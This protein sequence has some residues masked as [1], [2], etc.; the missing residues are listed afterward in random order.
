[1]SAKVSTVPVSRVF[2]G[3]KDASCM[4]DKPRKH[5]LAVLG[6]CLISI[7]TSNPAFGGEAVY[8]TS[9]EKHLSP[10]Y[11]DYAKGLVWDTAKAHS[12]A[13]SLL[14]SRNAD[15]VFEGKDPNVPMP[16][17]TAFWW[18]NA[19][20]SIEPST[21]YSISSWALSELQKGEAG[22]TISYYSKGGR[23]LGKPTQFRLVNGP[24][25][26]WVELGGTITTPPDA[27]GIKVGMITWDTE[28]RVWFDDLAIRTGPWEVTVP[29]GTM[30]IDGVVTPEKWQGAAV[31]KDFEKVGTSGF[32]RP[33]GE[34]DTVVFM[35]TDWQDL[36][37]GAICSVADPKD[38]VVS[39]NKRD[40]S[41]WGDSCLEFF[42]DLRGDGASYIHYAVNAGGAYYDAYWQDGAES[43]G[44]DSTVRTAVSTQ[45]DAWM[46]ELA[47]PL[48]AF[49][50]NPQDNSAR[51]MKIAMNVCREEKGGV[52]LSSWAPLG[53]KGAFAA[54]ERFIATTIDGNPGSRSGE[55][56]FRYRDVQQTERTKTVRTWR[57]KDPL[58]RELISD[59]PRKYPDNAAVMWSHPVW[60]WIR[61]LA[62]QYGL[63]WD[64][65]ARARELAEHNVHLF[66]SYFG[67][68]YWPREIAEETKCLWGLMMS[69]V[70][71]ADKTEFRGASGEALL[72]DPENRKVWLKRLCAYMDEWPSWCVALGDE[73]VDS[74]SKSFFAIKQKYG[75]KYPYLRE[76]RRDIREN[77]GFGKYGCPDSLQDEDPFKWIAFWRWFLDQHLA[78]VRDFSATA[79]ARKPDIVTIGDDPP[80]GMNVSHIS[81]LGKYIDIF[82]GQ[83]YWPSRNM[84]NFA[85]GTKLTVD[86]SGKEVWPLPHSEN[87]Y[88]S[89]DDEELNDMLS[90][91][92]RVGA[93]GFQF[94][95]CDTAGRSRNVNVAPSCR[96]G[97]RPRWDAM[98][99]I[100]DKMRTMNRLTFP[101]PDSAV[102]FAE[103]T[104]HSVLEI[105]PVY[106]PVYN[107][108]FTMMGP[109]TRAWFKYVSD[110]QLEDRDV[111]LGKYNVLFVPSAK[112]ESEEVRA[113]IRAY[114]ENGGTLVILDPEAF[115]W[116]VDGTDRRDFT[117]ALT[118]ATLAGPTAALAITSSKLGRSPHNL[119]LASRSNRWALQPQTTTEVLA[120]YDNGKPAVTRKSGG[121]GTVYYFAV[122]PC[123]EDIVYSASWIAFFRDFCATLGLKTGQ[124]IWRF[125]FD[126]PRFEMPKEV[127]GTC[128]TNNYFQWVLNEPILAGNAS[129]PD[130][131]Y[132]YDG[133]KPDLY[134]EAAE[135][136]FRRGKLTDRNRAIGQVLAKEVYA[137]GESTAPAYTVGWKDVSACAVVFDLGEVREISTVRAFASGEVPRM[138]VRCGLAEPE[139]EEAIVVPAPPRGDG[140]EVRKLEGTFPSRRARY[141]SLAFA[142]RKEKPFIITEVDIW[143]K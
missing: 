15:E 112:Y 113:Q 105:G 138:L 101:T 3:T 73:V 81:R 121:K 106:R 128:L 41:V 48:T 133:V 5:V 69:P 55:Y 6:T 1:M 28:G 79:R 24:T 122:N 94:Y 143:G 80:W 87:Y 130:G 34:Q 76:A 118:G 27:G 21:T 84:Q 78:T 99:A 67:W 61:G 119:K 52:T 140:I 23:S 91:V 90:E 14:I 127:E 12:G 26:G 45:P 92:V 16:F 117:A 42:F 135:V 85:F 141:V 58:F 96:E 11:N 93:T 70:Y 97:H 137:S 129:L 35:K 95:I 88:F 108:L 104:C 37:I 60:P 77:Y 30:K 10:W 33:A 36:Y 51:R 9:F 72:A 131:K 110:I 53:T 38:I 83:Q 59:T 43:A 2:S 17:D 71:A 107:S 4:S 123:T 136:P 47:I 19:I 65:H 115:T 32:P 49:G 66:I 114:V 54:P 98:L 100:I 75:D 102:L 63:E 142:A 46:C 82:A 68:P 134:P 126:I 39:T 8:Q 18:S 111:D 125:R 25:P 22:L 29:Y 116:G 74:Q 20:T 7:V 56:S 139:M 62:L 64:H 124:D 132:R 40:G 50:L 57:V 89:M 86:L 13:R 44:W 31:L 120:T 109:R 103:N